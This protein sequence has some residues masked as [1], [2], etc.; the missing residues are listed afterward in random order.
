[1][2]KVCKNC[3]YFVQVSSDLSKFIWGDCMKDAKPVGPDGKKERGYFTWADRTCIDFKPRQEHSKGH[4][5][6]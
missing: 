2:K 1:M 6:L 4:N 3:E 5:K